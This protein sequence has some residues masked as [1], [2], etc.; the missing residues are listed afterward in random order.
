[1]RITI[2]IKEELA[3]EIREVA[4]GKGR[5]VSSLVAEAVERYIAE[6]RKREARI[7]ILEIACRVYVASDAVKELERERWDED[8]V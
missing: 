5:S 4:R 6:L 3:K 7:K 2:N 8:R 1:M